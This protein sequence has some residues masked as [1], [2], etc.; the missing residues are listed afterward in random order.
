M[1]RLQEERGQAFLPDMPRIDGLEHVVDHLWQVGPTT[2]DGAVTHAELHYYQR[3]TGVELSEWEANAIR[4]LSVEYL[5]E[6]HRA[7]D[8]RYPSPWAEGEQVKVIATNTARN[9]IRALASL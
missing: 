1:K 2:G 7:T 9:A 3:N 4:R 6:S 5:N 8:P